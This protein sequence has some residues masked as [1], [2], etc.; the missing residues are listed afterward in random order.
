MLCRETAKS[1]KFIALEIY[2]C[3]TV[4]LQNGFTLQ[5]LGGIESMAITE[6]FGGNTQHTAHT[7]YTAQS[8]S[9]LL[10]LNFF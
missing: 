2:L 9:T 6:V 3:C 5:I 1:A 10:F 8:T 4:F 7:T